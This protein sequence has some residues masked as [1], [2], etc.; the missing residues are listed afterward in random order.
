VNSNIL[1]DANEIN[2]DGKKGHDLKVFSFASIVAATDN[3]S[4]ENKL[5]QGGFG[6]VYKVRHI[7][8][9]YCAF[10]NK[11]KALPSITNSGKIA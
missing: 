2:N 8:S 9:S 6:P 4:M 3:F 5:G 11:F 1:G 10:V 7:Y